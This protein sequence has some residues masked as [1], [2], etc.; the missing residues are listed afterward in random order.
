MC[1]GDY[2]GRQSDLIN[3]NQIRE[4]TIF[5]L[6]ETHPCLS[7]FAGCLVS[8]GVCLSPKLFSPLGILCF[9]SAYLLLVPQTQLAPSTL[10]ASAYTLRFAWNAL[11]HIA[12]C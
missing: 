10:F 2:K 11:P 9:S 7:Y 5:K 8:P 3:P 12:T 1:D 4:E 6:P